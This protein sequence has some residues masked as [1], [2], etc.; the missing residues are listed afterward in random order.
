MAEGNFRKYLRRDSVRVKKYFY[1]LRPV[2]AC[3]WIQSH[4][5]M[6]PMQFSALVADQLPPALR[7]A[8]EELLRRKRVGDEL[9]SGPRVPEINEFLEK[10]LPRLRETLA[11]IPGRPKPDWDLL[12]QIFR[13]SLSEAWMTSPPHG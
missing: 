11:A 7:P 5:S 10:E 12:D 1:V 13:D 6:P 4:E 8:V 3:R 9:D 2:L